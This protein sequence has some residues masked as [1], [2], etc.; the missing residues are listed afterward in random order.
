[1]NQLEIRGL[2]FRGRG[3]YDL[4]VRAGEIVGLK[5]PS[6]AGKTLLLRAVADLDP[7]GGSASINGIICRDVPAPL[8]RR[9]V[10]MLPAESGWWLDTVKEHFRSF[11][12]LPQSRLARLGFD[13]SVGN[14]RI[15]RLSTGEKQRLAILRLLE[16]QP[17]ALLLDEPTASLDAANISRVERLFRDYARENDAPILWVSH[18]PEQL[19]RL[20]S[21]LL[22]MN[23]DGTLAGTGEKNG[24]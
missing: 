17:R 2:S 3:P 15:S 12:D 13:Y 22:V 24:G 6:G 16:N 21:R 5:G 20:A 4:T 19:H 14:W 11:R 18:D 23:P 10:A 7:H 1:M 8:W 9:T